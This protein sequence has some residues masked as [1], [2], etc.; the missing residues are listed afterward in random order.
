MINVL[1]TG[2]SGNNTGTQILSA[3]RMIETKYRLIT[4]D[5]N[6]PN[7][8]SFFSDKSYIVPRAS[9]NTYL[10]S[11]MD[12]CIKEN[13]EVLIPGSEPELSVI[14]NNRDI[15]ESIGVHLLINNYSV[16][17]L[18]QNKLE[19]MNFL[20]KSGFPYIPYLVFDRNITTE[21]LLERTISALRFPIVIK[22]YLNSGGSINTHIIQDEDEFI[23]TAGLL[24]KYF[25]L[26]L[27]IQEYVGS[28]SEEYTVGVFSS[29]DGIAFSSFEL[30]RLINSS[31]TKKMSVENRYRSRIKSEE[32]VIST[33]I[34]QG[35]VNDFIEIRSFCMDAAN[36]LGSTGPLNI[37]CRLVDNE[38]YIF[39]IN[40]RFSGTTSIRALC[41]HNDPDIMIGVRLLGE[42]PIQTS[43][44]H[45]LVLRSLS[46]NFFKGDFKD[47]M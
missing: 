43:Y 33:G 23:V 21:E 34:S 36:A 2:T 42:K 38:I 18:C 8:G 9:S 3:L 41:G 30:K 12:I 35:H 25:D 40:P 4:T 31:F 6:S 22:P 10:K 11:I 7:F 37:Q 19:T 14:S 1:V 39:E 15:F 46:N 24:S 44:Q 13:V 29:N 32:L 17:K 45:G 27:I 26:N 16:I 5:I 20:K 47:T 28:C